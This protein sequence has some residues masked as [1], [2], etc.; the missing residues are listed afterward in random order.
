[1]IAAVDAHMVGQ[2]AAGDAGNGRFHTLLIQALGQTAADGDRVAA[3]IAHDAARELIGP[4]PAYAEVSA[5]NGRRLAIDVPRTLREMG[6]DAAVFSYVV[7]PR[8]P[9]PRV[10][11][12]HDVLFRLHPE[13]FSRRVRTLLNRLVPLSL[14]RARSIVTVSQTSRADLIDAF[15]VDPARVH[16]VTNVPAPAFHPREGAA[17]RVRE[18]HGLDRYCLYVGDVHP[19]K[20]L[21]ALAE[22]IRLVGDRD[23]R[24]A[25]VGRAGHRGEELIAA[26]GGIWLGPQGDQE[27]AD[28]YS[29]AAVTCN[30]SLYEGFGLP[31]VEAMACGSPVVASHRGAIPEVAGDA[32]L[33]V[34]PY[35]GPI[36]DGIRAALEP[37]TAEHL[38]RAG[39]ERASLFSMDTMG[40][41]GWDAIRAATT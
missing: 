22:A 40:A 15:D 28:L 10:V 16:V 24:L 18:R 11:V 12:V 29:A 41:Q 5:H 6:A 4:G 35:P 3:L 13:W 23:L 14:R 34:E 8:S 21:V 38:R 2:P 7:P 32:A 30:P 25:V 9:C 20:N 1:M 36:A 19:R 27:L 39:R 31:V 26:S 37:A 33:L 17:D